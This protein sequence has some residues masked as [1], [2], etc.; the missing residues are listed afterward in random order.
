MLFKLPDFLAVISVPRASSGT[1]LPL[2]FCHES[3]DPLQGPLSFPSAFP[4][5]LESSSVP[6]AVKRDRERLFISSAPSF[7]LDLSIRIK[8]VNYEGSN[9][10]LSIFQPLYFVPGQQKRS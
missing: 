10:F 4:V 9:F 5:H 6:L 7:Q 3:L 2:L 8:P 1:K